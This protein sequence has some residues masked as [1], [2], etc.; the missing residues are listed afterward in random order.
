V[1]ERHARGDAVDE[2][3]LDLA[4]AF[5]QMHACTDARAALEALI[6]NH[7]DSPLADRARAKLREIRRARPA[8][9][10]S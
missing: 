10:T 2:T 4:D 9:C 8:D 1:L 6:Q 7:A 3:L 5:W